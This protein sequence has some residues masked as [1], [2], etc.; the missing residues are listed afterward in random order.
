[1]RS[2]LAAAV[3]RLRGG[4]LPD[5]P[6]R[7]DRPGLAALER[8]VRAGRPPRLPAGV[9]LPHPPEELV[10]YF[11]DVE[12]EAL[13]PFL[14]PGAR[15]GAP[16]PGVS[17]VIPASRHAPVGL[18]A[19][20]L[21]DVEVEP[22]VLAN[23]GWSGP[24]AIPVRWEGHGRTRMRG[25][26]RASFPYVLFTVDDALP[27]GAGFLRTLVEALERGGF[28]AV[29]ARQ[30][31]WPTADAVTRARLRTWTPPGA[32]AVP[33]TR[34]DHVCALHRVELLRAD[35][36]DDVPIGE[37]WAW[38]RRHRVGYVP[39]APVAHSHP[40]RFR[41]LYTRTRALHAVF[42]EH[43]EA[44]RV[45][46]AAS[47]LRALPSTLGPDLRGALGEL[48]GQYAAARGRFHV[49]PGGAG[50]PG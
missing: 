5:A 7:L 46:D 17:V 18:D 26:E 6:C 45:P 36:L 39:A 48:L 1:M 25:V 21:Q 9:P 31:P 44:P 14:A 12:D 47:L 24:G 13:R 3:T 37:D 34:L 33:T 16:L 8:A 22:L 49:E 19:L 20:L 15:P 41:A 4:S 35:P 32:A 40:R 23:G 42:H 11:H 27:L 29:Y 10:P 43:G 38:G 2:R 30:L 28:D 50:R